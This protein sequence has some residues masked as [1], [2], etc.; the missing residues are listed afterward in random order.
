[1]S[2]PVIRRCPTASRKRAGERGAT[3]FETVFVVLLMMLALV[4]L[5][6]F[7]LA[8]RSYNALGFVSR[9]AA[10]YASVRSV[11]S[12]DPATAASVTAFARG[13]RAGIDPAK[14]QVSVTWSPTNSRGSSVRVATNYAYVPMLGLLPFEGVALSSHSQRTIT[15]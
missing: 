11:T 10:R 1:M 9:E 3:A 5:F 12:R 13:L 8:V 15:E 4:G 6:D 14:L 7:G 2:R